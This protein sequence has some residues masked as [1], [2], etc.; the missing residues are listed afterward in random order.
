MTSRNATGFASD[1]RIVAM[2]MTASCAVSSRIVALPE[3]A[4]HEQE[5]ADLDQPRGAHLLLQRAR[6]AL[7]HPLQQAW[8][9]NTTQAN[10]LLL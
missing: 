6:S 8:I 5:V 9:R 7:R 1:S 4:P 2:R 3:L 10:N